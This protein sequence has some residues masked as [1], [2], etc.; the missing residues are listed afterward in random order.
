M[1]PGLVGANLVFAQFPEQETGGHKA[2][3][4]KNVSQ[5]VREK[6]WRTRTRHPASN[7]IS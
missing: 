7:R 4:Y 2:R 5:P 3:P 1:C 6:S